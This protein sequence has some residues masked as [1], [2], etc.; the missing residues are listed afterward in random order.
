MI[1]PRRTQK[2]ISNRY[3][4]NLD[5][6]SRAHLWRA[7][8]W[9]VS[10]LVLVIGFAIAISYRKRGDER[11]FSSGPLSRNH[12]MLARDCRSCHGDSLVKGS[13]LTQA[14]FQ[15]TVSNQFRRG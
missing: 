15:Q 14:K 2:Q 3:Q 6:Y 8:R 13:G 4:G 11:F 10:F 7:A 1:F 12:A 9:L 5:Y